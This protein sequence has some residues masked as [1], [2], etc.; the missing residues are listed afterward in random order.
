MAK[1]E[2]EGDGHEEMEETNANGPDMAAETK[3]C[4]GLAFRN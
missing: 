1:E 4:E 3:M 2:L